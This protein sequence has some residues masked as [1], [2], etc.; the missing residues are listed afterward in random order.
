MIKVA[1]ISIA[2]SISVMLIAVAIVTGFRNEIRNKLAGFGSH[3]QVC[4][5]S[6]NYLFESYPILID[7]MLVNFLENEKDIKKAQYFA[8][9]PGIIR[10]GEDIQGII[11]K[12]V[13]WN[14]DWSFFEYYLKKG[15]IPAI[16]NDTNVIGTEVLISSTIARRLK[17]DVGDTITT[18]FINQAGERLP[19]VKNLQ[20]PPRRFIVSG[21]YETGLLEMDEK[22]IIG[23]IKQVQVLNNWYFDKASG[24]EILV[25]DFSK[26]DEVF[27]F[28]YEN[29]DYD[30]DAKS[31]KDMYPEIFIW[32]DYQNVNVYIILTLMIVVSVMAMISTLLILILEKTNFI[33]ILKA[34]GMP[35]SQVRK[36]FYYQ[37]AS[38]ILRGLVIGNVMSLTLLL[39]QKKY[40]FLKLD[41]ELYYVDVVPV[42]IRL[43]Y[44]C[45]VNIGSLL[46]CLAAMIIPT[47]IISNISPLKAIRFD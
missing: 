39:L 46:I 38:I 21:I 25:T 27:D 16:E 41:Q 17:T 14:F 13:D 6:D 45:M 47:S 30:Q 2:L 1:I 28:V 40:G 34:L 15:K 7:Q 42:N 22:F 10:T 20:R 37:A 9:K 19:E 43:D 23:D 4:A 12:G 29:I 18:F 26:L 11:L 3:I 5:Y 35:N 8:T 44:L 33:G 24:L 36:V 31:I 32:L